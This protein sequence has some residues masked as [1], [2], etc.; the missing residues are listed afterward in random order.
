MQTRSALGEVIKARRIELGWT[1]EELAERVSADGEFVRQSEISRIE[2]GRIALPRR[3][4]LERIAQALGLPLGELLARSG[5]AGAEPHFGSSA[6]ESDAERTPDGKLNGPGEA[7]IAPDDDPVLFEAEWVPVGA[8]SRAKTTTYDPDAL[9]ALRRAL[10]RMR[11]EADRL[12]HNWSV[13]SVMQQRF[14][15]VA[16]DDRER[17]PQADYSSS[18]GG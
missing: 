11:M 15:I 18:A 6:T 1:Q 8:L 7:L 12:Q 5:W 16:D 13:A 3:E 17:R 14:R 9:A 4:R 2:N 10:A